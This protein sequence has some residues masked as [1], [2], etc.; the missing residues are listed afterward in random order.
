MEVKLERRYPCPMPPE[1]AWALLKDVRAVAACLPGASLDEQIDATHYRGSV[2]LRVGPATAQFAGDLEVLSLDE[3]A[4][5]LQLR[6]KG[7]DKA[8][9]SAAME[10]SAV[11]EPGERPAECVLAGVSTITVSGKFAQLG[12]HLLGQV[13]DAILA[14]FVDNFRAAAAPPPGPGTETNTAGAG[15]VA[16][17]EVSRPPAADDERAATVPTPARTPPPGKPDAELNALGLAWAVLKRWLAGLF[18]RRT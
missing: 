7:A 11:I 15:G 16:R 12:G 14:Q 5:H 1:Q 9:S 8:G 3:A 4:R 2:K 6:G 13:S 18:G 17:P 10:L